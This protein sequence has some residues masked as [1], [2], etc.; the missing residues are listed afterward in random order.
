MVA[1][2]LRRKA[3]DKPTHAWRKDFK[4]N[5]A[6][7]FFVLPA[8]VAGAEVS[9]GA[10]VTAVNGGSDEVLSSPFIIL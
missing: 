3:A 1:R 6:L 8:V 7:Y 10:D 4:Q 5:R 2:I 9:G